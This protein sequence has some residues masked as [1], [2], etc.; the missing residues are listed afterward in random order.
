MSVELPPLPPLP[1]LEIPGYQGGPYSHQPDLLREPLFLLAHL[2]GCV[3]SEEAEE[4]L[5]GADYEAAAEFQRALMEAGGWPVF[6]LPLAAGHWLY[7][8]YRTVEDESGVDYLV[9]H[10]EWPAVE[11]IASDEGSFSGPGLSWAE[12]RAAAGNGIGGGSTDDPDARLLLLLPALGDDQAPADAAGAVAGALAALTRVEDPRRAAEH[13]LAGQ[14]PAGPARWS[15]GETGVW[16]CDGTYAHRS[17][18][19][20]PGERLARISAA[21]HQR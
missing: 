5:F 14:G 13:L 20:L 7:V 2:Y 8:V 21:L 3:H 17:T 6:A 1:Q 4:A 10:P 9:H 15:V 12:L 16:T 19:A 11:T 18:G